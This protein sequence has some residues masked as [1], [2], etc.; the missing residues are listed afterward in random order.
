[1]LPSLLI[2][3]AINVPAAPIPRDTLPNP[4]GPVPR[5]LALK[6]N[7]AGVVCI[8][9][10]TYEKQIVQHQVFVS[11]NGKQI[12][13]QQDQEVVIPNYVHKDIG[14][15]GGKFATVDGFVLTTEQTIRIIRDGATILITADGKSID[16][17]W[18][19]AVSKNTIVM[20]TDELPRAHFQYGHSSLPTTPAPRLVML[21]T[22]EKG[23]VRTPVN[24]NAY[25]VSQDDDFVGFPNNAARLLRRR[26]VAIVNGN[27]MLVGTADTGAA[28]IKPPGPDGKKTLAE[29]RFD[30]YDLTGKLIPKAEAMKRLKAGG[31]VLVA[32]DN[33]FPDT[34]YLKA[35]HEDLIVLVSPEL[36]FPP[37]TPNPYDMPAKKPEATMAKTAAPATP[38]VMPAAA[39]KIQIAPALKLNPVAPAAPNKE[40]EPRAD[41][42]KE[43][44][45][46]TPAKP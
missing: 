31:L 32:S 6:A 21:G 3:A 39:L 45:A 4:T 5:I 26:R 23:S 14:D 42:A 38:Q 46:T 33:Q 17:S 8:I 41:R 2:A 9:A 7:E 29:I 22:D 10:T 12:L 40:A 16:K 28:A 1:M 15:F 11:E 30:A 36:T 20:F 13:K 25:D 37:T 44:P 43:N 27:A 35:F 24:P 18:L 34:E 19:R